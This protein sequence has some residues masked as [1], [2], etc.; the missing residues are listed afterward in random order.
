MPKEPCKSLTNYFIKLGNQIIIT[1]CVCRKYLKYLNLQ[2]CDFKFTSRTSKLNIKI[3]KDDTV[4][5]DSKDGKS[6]I[7]SYM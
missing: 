6:E 1:Y 5:Y 7:K 4:V 2:S 3:E